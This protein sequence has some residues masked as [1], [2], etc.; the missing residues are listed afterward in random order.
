[1]RVRKWL[2]AAGAAVLVAA[3]AVTVWMVTPSD[4]TRGESAFPQDAVAADCN[5]INVFPLPEP[6][7]GVTPHFGLAYDAYLNALP[8]YQKAVGHGRYPLFWRESSRGVVRYAMVEPTRSGGWRVDTCDGHA[9]IW[10]D[11]LRMSG[12]NG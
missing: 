11:Y 12:L 1:V 9:R 5:A 8:A 4:D 6:R 10:S 3:V 2:I 7:Q